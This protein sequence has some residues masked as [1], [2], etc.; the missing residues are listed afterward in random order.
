MA[1][2]LNHLNI[3]M[4]GGYHKCNIVD[5]SFKAVFYEQSIKHCKRGKGIGRPKFGHHADK[6]AHIRRGCDPTVI[7][8]EH[9]EGLEMGMFVAITVSGVH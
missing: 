1:D 6:S 4:V 5:I 7:S 3:G 2:L 9:L 8:P